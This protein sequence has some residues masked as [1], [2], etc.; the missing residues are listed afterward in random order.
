MPS[1]NEYNSKLTTIRLDIPNSLAQGNPMP[2]I[3]SGTDYVLDMADHFDR[4][5]IW[6]NE[7]NG[8]NF[9]NGV[10]EKAIF[11]FNDQPF[12]RRVRLV[13][14]F[15]DGL[16]PYQGALPQVDQ[17]AF[18]TLLFGSNITPNNIGI[19]GNNNEAVIISI[20]L[21]N[22]WVEVGRFVPINN[23]VDTSG[24]TFAG[25]ASTTSNLIYIN[26][27]IQY[28]LTNVIDTSFNG[29]TPNFV[30]EAEVEHTFDLRE[31]F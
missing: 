24:F 14:T 6:V 22:T 2:V 20:P 27:T 9:T 5:L 25:S 4:D 21:L 31:V 1:N 11:D 3:A 30:F 16:I 17:F 19:D 28:F 29:I 13:A 15:G 18:E 23:Y 12:V 10:R 8:A 7:V 26:S